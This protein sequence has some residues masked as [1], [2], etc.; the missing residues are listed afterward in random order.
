MRVCQGCYEIIAHDEPAVRCSSCGRWYHA[1][2]R[3][4]RIQ[5][6]KEANICYRCKRRTY[7]HRFCPRCCELIYSV[8]DDC[9]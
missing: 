9:Y 2:A 7:T 6:T 3:C 1:W 5:T 4:L 8:C